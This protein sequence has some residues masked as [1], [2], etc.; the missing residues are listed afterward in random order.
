MLPRCSELSPHDGDFGKSL[1]RFKEWKPIGDSGIRWLKIHLHNLMEGIEI[2]G[3]ASS[4][5]KGR[6]FDERVEWVDRNVRKPSEKL[7]E[8]LP[9]TSPP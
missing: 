4:A 2:E 8:I 5:K 1:I 7:P 3:M 6:S 9:N